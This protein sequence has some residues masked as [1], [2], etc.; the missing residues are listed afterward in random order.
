MLVLSRKLNESIT[1]GD[2]I[3]IVVVEI[4]NDQ[5]RLGIN[6]PRRIAVHR[7]EVYKKIQRENVMA[8]KVGKDMVD[9]AVNKYDSS[10]RENNLKK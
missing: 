1:V 7:R 2:D 4:K 10:R 6:A 9:K 8:S 5:V 3:E